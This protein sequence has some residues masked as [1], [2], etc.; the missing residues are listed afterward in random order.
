[1]RCFLLLLAMMA[2]TAAP[3]PASARIQPDIVCWES[4]LE[5]PIACDDDE[6]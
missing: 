2:A 6:D 3:L 4:D 1:M 5:F